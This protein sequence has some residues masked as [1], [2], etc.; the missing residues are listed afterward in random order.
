MLNLGQRLL[1]YIASIIFLSGEI[2][3]AL[4]PVCRRLGAPVVRLK[5]PFCARLLILLFS[6]YQVI[7]N[8]GVQHTQFAMY[9]SRA[10]V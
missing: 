4:A 6:R 9:K 8:R 5:G 7:N 2:Q 1:Q 3:D 10:Y